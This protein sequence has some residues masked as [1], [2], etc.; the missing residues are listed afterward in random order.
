MTAGLPELLEPYATVT[1]VGLAKNAGKTTVVNH[2]LDRLEGPDRAGL[3]GA[4]RGGPRQLT[5]LPKPRITPP[6]GTLV[7]TADGLAGELR[8]AARL[9]FEPRSERWCWSNRS[10]GGR[11][12]CR[13]RPA[14]AGVIINTG[15][16]NYL[17]T[18]PGH[19]SGH[20]VVASNII[21][22]ALAL[23]AG[24]PEAQIGLGHAFEID[25]DRPGQLMEEWAIP[26]LCPGTGRDR[27][28]TVVGSEVTRTELGFAGTNELIER[29]LGRQAGGRGGGHRVGRAHGRSTRS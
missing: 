22:R 24:L 20:T 26:R 10:P 23:R 3:A 21:N 2:L 28:D 6:A 11:R 14:R 8:V 15:E 9:P 4:G 25:P 12:S 13:G 5:G 16:D 17:T 27:P 18:S 7:A 29:Q 1:V 19:E